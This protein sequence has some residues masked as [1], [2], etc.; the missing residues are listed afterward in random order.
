[1]ANPVI[2][3]SDTNLNYPKLV[4][5]NTP[6]TAEIEG[7]STI[8]GNT[9]H[10]VWAV[11][12]NNEGVFLKR[13]KTKT[14]YSLYKYIATEI[15]IKDSGGYQISISN[16]GTGTHKIL[17][18]DGFASES[19]CGYSGMS[20]VLAVQQ[21]V[22]SVDQPVQFTTT[23]TLPTGLS[24]GTTYYIR[25]AFNS[26]S[27]DSMRVDN[28]SYIKE[29][30]NG[31]LYVFMSGHNLSYRGIAG[32]SRKSFW[33]STDGGVSWNCILSRLSSD[34][35]QILDENLTSLLNFVDCGNG[36]LLFI[37]Y[38]DFNADNCIYGSTD[39]GETWSIKLRVRGHSVDW[40]SNLR[41]FH[42]G[43]WFNDRLFIF[44]GDVCVNDSSVRPPTYQSF[45]SIMVCNDIDDFM[46]GEGNWTVNWK[47]KWG[48]LD[49]ND[50]I[51]INGTTYSIVHSSP[52]GNQI[53][54]R[55]RP[56]LDPNYFA[57]V[58]SADDDQSSLTNYAITT[59]V[60]SA[61]ENIVDSHT[62]LTFKR[63]ALGHTYRLTGAYFETIDGLDYI[64]FGV[65]QGSLNANGS[66][67]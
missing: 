15:T 9:R 23:G 53:E 26:D 17:F 47:E 58:V 5:L 48:L 46:L 50:T 10:G 62:G 42:G 36:R 67:I 29:D 12:G 52:V 66:R 20:G 4:P 63:I 43:M 2:P 11:Y 28:I 22:F 8:V 27:P 44:T 55:F 51:T 18:G 30:T 21:A 13:F 60:S 6:E 33:R 35:P 16:A 24:V 31:N 61:F 45:S 40:Q 1:M 57:M 39:Y 49:Q 64:Y 54:R 7:C 32:V 65:D 3:Y 19:I 59:P 37:N 41:H 25:T 34:S 14:D 56:G 38:A